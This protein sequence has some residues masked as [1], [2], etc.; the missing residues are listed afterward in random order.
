MVTESRQTGQLG[1]ELATR[2]LLG[3]GFSLLHRNWRC[4]RYELDL[5]AS[6]QGVLHIVEVKTRRKGALTS[7]E[8]ALDR[9]KSQSLVRAARA[10]LA[11]HPFVGEVQ[12]D[13]IA[14][15]IDPAGPPLL[16]YIEQTVELHW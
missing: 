8:Q 12:F 3:E 4:G 10:Y 11:Q 6:K 14:V 15:E 13:L 7:P 5:V 2:W 9:R 1:E 16:R